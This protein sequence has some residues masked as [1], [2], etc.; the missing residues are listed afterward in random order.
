MQIKDAYR[1]LC[2]QYHPDL[3]TN[4][5]SRAV[6]EVCFKEISAA[7]AA[8]SRKGTIGV[9]IHISRIIDIEL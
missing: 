8:L 3:C 9:L 6:A 5:D 7:Y 1:K 4:N 2:L